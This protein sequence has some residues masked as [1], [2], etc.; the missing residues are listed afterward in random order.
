MI[1]FDCKSCGREIRVPEIHAGKKGKCPKCNSPILV[2]HIENQAAIGQTNAAASKAAPKNPYADLSL[3]DIPEAHKTRAQPTSHGAPPDEALKQLQKLE[4]LIKPQ[5]AKTLAKRK[6]P[7]LIDIFLYPISTPG[8]IILMIVVGIPLL[9][10]G[11]AMLLGVF[12]FLLA[13]PGLVIKIVIFLYMYWY[14]S[15]CIRDSAD[16]GIRAPDVLVNAPSIGDMLSQTLTI[17]GTLAFFVAPMAVYHLYA[18]TTDTAFWLL[19]A[20]AVLFFPMGLLAV[21]MFD[22]LSGL[23]PLLLVGSMFSTFFPYCAMVLVFFL[24]GLLLKE[25]TPDTRQS[26]PLTFLFT[27]AYIYLAM[28]AAH[29]L[30]RFYHRYQEK[31]NWEV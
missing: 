1:K 30:G 29:I 25:C 11:L 24:A 12:A 19:L 28:V 4:Q 20:Y 9:I 14:F 21:I 31:L 27:C 10:D 17:G 18:K 6:F 16:G 26:L 8:L 3:L 13:I 2:P 15:E 23:N 5:E 22:S 7:W